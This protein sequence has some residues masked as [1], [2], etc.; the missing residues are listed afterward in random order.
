MHSVFSPK[1]R[2]ESVRERKESVCVLK[3][4]ADECRSPWELRECWCSQ[5]PCNVGEPGLSQ[6]TFP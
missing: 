5:L 3:G 2:E 4:V 1:K 6:L